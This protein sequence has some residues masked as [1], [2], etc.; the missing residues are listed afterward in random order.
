ML[1]RI[2]PIAVTILAAVTMTAHAS[3]ASAGNSA[4]AIAEGIA[5]PAAKAELTTAPSSGGKATA[6]TSANAAP[7]PAA[8]PVAATIDVIVPPVKRVLPKPVV[9]KAPAKDPKAVKADTPKSGSGKTKAGT[10]LEK[11]A[12]KAAVNPAA[13]APQKDRSNAVTENEKSGEKKVSRD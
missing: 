7:A 10:P 11:V 4:Q 6:A 9:L 12:G 13:K 2:T 3:P 5:A 8:A 1:Q